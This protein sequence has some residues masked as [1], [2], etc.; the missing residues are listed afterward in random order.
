MDNIT[1]YYTNCISLTAGVQCRSCSQLY[2][3]I[4]CNNKIHGFLYWK[5]WITTEATKLLNQ[6]YHWILCSTNYSFPKCSDREDLVLPCTTK[7]S[8]IKFV[9]NRF[10]VFTF[11]IFVIIF[12]QQLHSRI[13]RSFQQIFVSTT[14]ICVAFLLPFHSIEKH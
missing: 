13:D 6:P 10:Q 5:F 2:E 11:E 14:Y 12:K 1:A 4:M 3:L 7:K 8:S 9:L